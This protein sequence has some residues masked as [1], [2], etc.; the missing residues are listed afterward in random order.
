MKYKLTDLS[1]NHFEYCSKELVSGTVVNLKYNGQLLEFQTPKVI[2]QDIIKES[3]KEF[4][5]LQIL[6][7]L[8]CKKFFDKIL[9]FES[10]LTEHFNLP[11]QSIF[12]GDH[13]NVKV[14]VPSV[15][16]FFNGSLFNY[17]H[18]RKGME[19][20]CLVQCDKM[21][22]SNSLNYHLHVKEIMLLKK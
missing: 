18:L 22:I 7:T 4:L 17:Y 11:I 5:C 2:I 15:E 16:V 12:K 6:G 1:F 8:A 10:V 19:I 3:D 14:Q 13:F 9:E 20:I 21:W